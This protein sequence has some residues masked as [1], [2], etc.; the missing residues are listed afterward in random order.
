MH[1]VYSYSRFT[2]IYFLKHKSDAFDTFLKFKALAELQ[3]NTKI[4]DV[5]SDGGEEFIPISK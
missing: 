1:F 5:Q 3:F 4:K 2:W